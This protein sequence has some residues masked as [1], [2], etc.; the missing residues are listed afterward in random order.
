MTKPGNT[1]ST[2]SLISLAEAAR[3]SGK[4]F[5]RGH[6]DDL[7]PNASPTLEELAECVYFAPGDGRIWLNDQRM[8]LFHSASL[9]RIRRE[10]I[11]LVGRERAQGLFTRTGYA[12]G[13]ADARLIR[14][15]W[16][17]EDLTHALA[18][19][20]RIHT[21]EG[22]VRAS[23]VRFDFDLER[24][25]YSGEFLW[26]ESSEAD[27]HLATFG[28]SNEPVCWLQTAYATGYTSWLF[29]KPI[30]FR[31]ME[32][33]GMGA[34]QC[35]CIAQPLD[36]WGPDAR[37]AD[38]EAYYPPT[39]TCESVSVTPAVG[40]SA[41]FMAARHMLDRVA[42]THATVLLT[43]ESGTGKELFAR[44]L[45][46]EGP[47]RA[48]PFV[49]LNCAA[50]PDTLVEAE[51]FGIEKG[52]YTGATSSRAGRFERADTGTLF[53]DEVASL[54]LVAQGKLLRAIQEREIERVGGSRTISVNVRLVAASNIDLRQAVAEGHFRQDLFFRLNV[55]PIE[56]PPLRARRDDIPLLMEH[57]LR[58]YAHEHAIKPRGFTRRAVES[59]LGYDYPGN[60]R[61]LQNLIE[62]G[63][64]FAGNDGLIDT[65]HMFHR[66]EV[67][68]PK[69]LQV[70]PTGGLVQGAAAEA[71]HAPAPE[72][73][74][75][76]ADMERE[77]Y[78]QALARSKGNISAAARELGLS[79]PAFEYRL[80]K[81][82]GAG[83]LLAI[84]D[85]Q[86][87]VRRP[88]PRRPP[89]G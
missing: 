11:E 84:T 25:H 47:R 61:E 57:F 21:L 58:L 69:L 12:Q 56:L 50:V 19:G 27:E 4:M 36:A 23:T 62:R 1:H 89:T 85:T 29:G 30:V 48:R 74:R 75:T 49:A 46:D 60:V 71:S 31:E 34:A 76:F 38:L 37:G 41:R 7:L 24:G 55:F 80:R 15:R 78:A 40:I 65:V 42:P 20:P 81:H 17:N 79:R 87:T 64:V 33:R 39:E 63:V 3:K 16:P 22:F 73:A 77:L 26:H 5:E 51:L 13:A 8:V 53:L 35:R 66:G 32:C 28:V 86:P 67:L 59:L 83:A 72:A 43:G 6:S 9:G 54:S 44:T 88:G 52:A 18:A 82:G 68:S 70:G 2:D 45:H 10:I 14:T